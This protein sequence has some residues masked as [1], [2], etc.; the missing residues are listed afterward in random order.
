MKAVVAGCFYESG[1]SR[2]LFMKSAAMDGRFLILQSRTIAE[3]HSWM[4]A[5]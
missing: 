1:C 3:I 2:S 4:A 5:F